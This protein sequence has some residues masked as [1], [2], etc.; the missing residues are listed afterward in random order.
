M[1][2]S[3]HERALLRG[4]LDVLELQDMPDMD[5]DRL[6]EAIWD[7]IVLDYKLELNDVFNEPVDLGRL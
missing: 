5:Q 2:I 6:L 4:K 3:E 7:D 1:N